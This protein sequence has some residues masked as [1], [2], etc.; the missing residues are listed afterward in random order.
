MSAN[1]GADG[2]I[3]VFSAGIVP[4]RLGPQGLQVLLLRVYSYWDFP[5]G[6]VHQGE[7]PLDG[8]LRELEEETA[9]RGAQFHW[10]RDYIETPPYARGKVARYYLAEL[11]AG[12]VAIRPNPISG[13]IEHH[14]H[15]WLSP[16]NARRLLV[17]RVAT[18]LEWALSRIERGHV[19]PLTSS[20]PDPSF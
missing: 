6:V 12:E 15:R 4:V 10:G 14:E 8:A 3:R 5:K 20:P 2:R 18:V 17:P 1:E 9:L 16:E 13:G 7:A 19:E 11:S